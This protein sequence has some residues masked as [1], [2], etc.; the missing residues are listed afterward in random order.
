MRGADLA[1]HNFVGLTKQSAAL[2]VPQHDIMDEQITKQR[3]ANFAC[4]CAPLFPIHILRAHFD[5]LRFAECFHHFWNRSERRHD[6][7]F[8]IGD[9]TQIQQHRLDKSRR[10]GLRHVHF[11]IS[12]DDFLSHVIPSEARNLA[13]YRTGSK[14]LRPCEIARYTRDDKLRVD[15]VSLS[16][17]WFLTTDSELKINEGCVVRRNK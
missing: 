15:D 11:P 3:G 14:S 5:V 4:E 7:H 17:G 10:L 12:S 8:H 1:I 13:T 9:V 2:A 6:H 16:C